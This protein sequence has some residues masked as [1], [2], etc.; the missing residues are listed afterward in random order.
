V[1]CAWWRFHCWDEW[2]VLYWYISASTLVLWVV[3]WL[4]YVPLQMRE[5]RCTESCKDVRICASTIAKP[6]LS[7]CAHFC[8]HAYIHYNILQVYYCAFVPCTK[9]A[10][11]HVYLHMRISASLFFSMFVDKWVACPF[12]GAT[13][14]VLVMSWSFQLSWV[15]LHWGGVGR[16]VNISYRT[17]PFPERTCFLSKNVETCWNMLKHVEPCWNMLKPQSRHLM[18]L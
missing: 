8:I 13:V 5:D 18:V 6:L 9:L 10:H 2:Q 15:W 14:H 11:M 1:L 4:S 12:F 16:D 3:V 7:K 17:K